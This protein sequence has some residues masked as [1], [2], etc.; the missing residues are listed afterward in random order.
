MFLEVTSLVMVAIC[1]NNKGSLDLRNRFKSHLVGLNDSACE[2]RNDPP[3][4]IIKKFQFCLCALFKTFDLALVLAFKGHRN[5]FGLK[6]GAWL[7]HKRR[8]FDK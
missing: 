6:Y 1:F 4:M 7:E 5:R 8:Y 3:L 2:K